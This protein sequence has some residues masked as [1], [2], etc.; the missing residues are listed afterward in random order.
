VG[1]MRRLVSA[2]ASALAL[3]AS[4]PAARGEEASDLLFFS[5]D[6]MSGRSFAGAGWLHAASGLES[7]GAVFQAELGDQ[8]SN[9]GYGQAAA[10]WRYSQPGLSTTLM[11]GVEFASRNTPAIRPLASGDLWWE[12]AKN[13]M[14]NAQIQATPDYVSWRIATGLRPLDN[15]PWVGPE[16]AASTGEW[17]VGVQATGIRLGGGLEVRVSAGVSRSAG[18]NGPYG[19]IGLWR[20][21]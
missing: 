3:A 5:G 7:S 18:R 8:Q 10:G 11:G 1:R 14:A 13:W 6:L 21:F 20:R 9:R 17:R 4:I 2:F 19:E 16:A 15:W 12:P